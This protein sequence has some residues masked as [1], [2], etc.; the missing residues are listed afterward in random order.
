MVMFIQLWRVVEPQVRHVLEAKPLVDVDWIQ[1]IPEIWCPVSRPQS[2]LNW[3]ELQT[4][5]GTIPRIRN[6]L[7]VYTLGKPNYE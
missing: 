5:S 6:G 2:S 7:L 3:F 1:S 4:S